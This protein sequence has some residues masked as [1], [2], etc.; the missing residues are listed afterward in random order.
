MGI[1]KTLVVLLLI[2]SI[3]AI[4]VK[5]KNQIPQVLGIKE[6]A[7][8]RVLSTP[9]GADVYIDNQPVGKTPFQ[10]DSL[11]ASEISIKLQS[12]SDFWE[13][14]VRL[15]SHTI[16]FVN[17][18]LSKDT[19]VAGEI[20]TLEPGSGVN[21]MSS[22]SGANVE[23]DG[24]SLGQTPGAFDVSS[25]DHTFVISRD[26]FLNRSIK[27]TVPSG[28]KL[29]ISVDLASSEEVVTTPNPS[30]TPIVTVLSTPT[31]FL[32]VRDKPS[33]SGKELA[34][35]KPSQELELVEELSGWD[36]VKLPDG[37]E[38]YVSSQYV[39]KE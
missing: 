38:G 2:I 20:L 10:S 7:G 3:V 22:P 17:R 31:G 37:T 9:D 5:F 15:G 27:A 18:S 26:G 13:G 6:S 14:K 34:Q 1:K 35:V 24:N 21:V 36:K 16:T 11:E 30:P 39:T 32:R 12:D 4:G 29:I 19:T 23:V 33:T 8:L 28:Y 25:S